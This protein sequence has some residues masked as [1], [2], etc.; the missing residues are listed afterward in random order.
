MNRGARRGPPRFLTA[1]CAVTVATA[2]GWASTQD[3]LA[4]RMRRQREAFA[5]GFDMA[6]EH[7]RL[8]GYVRLL[9]RAMGG[10]AA[11]AHPPVQA[12]P[13]SS[14]DRVQV[15]EAAARLVAARFRLASD[16]VSARFARIARGHAG[17]I[18]MRGGRAEV[19]VA[20]RHRDDDDLIVAVLAHEFA[21][22]A[23][24]RGLAGGPD[25]AMAEDECLV[26]A[27]AVMVG[28]GPIVL[29]ASFRERITGSARS[30]AW[31]VLRIGEL[32]PVA[33]AYLTLAHAELSGVDDDA[34]RVFVAR[35]MEPAWSFRRTQWEQL[36]ARRDARGRVA[37]CPTCLSD[38]SPAADA[39]TAVCATCGQR[40]PVGGHLESLQ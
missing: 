15:L 21:H 6:R 13:S 7:P 29:R 18:V 27:A 30:P 32:D 22:A 4:D 24:D 20:D 38:A 16:G 23:L 3:D 37:A 17:R 9:S 28:L 19:E 40:I 35:W 36:R 33:I 14:S 12:I 39:T 8:A 1:V 26:D 11:F 2:G 25:A 31:E 10:P 34:R 5:R